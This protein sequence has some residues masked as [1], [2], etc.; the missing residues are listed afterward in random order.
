MQLHRLGCA[1][2]KINTANQALISYSNLPVILRLQMSGASW[3]TSPMSTEEN[4]TN[5][6]QRYTCVTLSC[7][8]QAHVGRLTGLND[9]NNNKCILR[10]VVSLKAQCAL[11]KKKYRNQIMHKNTYKTNTI[12]LKVNYLNTYVLNNLKQNLTQYS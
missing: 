3:N 7:N 6:K 10:S 1:C 9:D 5:V 8:S 4:N 2:M 12:Y 11:Y